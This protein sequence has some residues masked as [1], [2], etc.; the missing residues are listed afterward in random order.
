ME[1]RITEARRQNLIT[2]E[3]SKAPVRL[4]TKDQLK[5]MGINVGLSDTNSLDGSFGE[6]VS[7]GFNDDFD[8]DA[9]ESA[10]EDLKEQD[11]FKGINLN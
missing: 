11:K 8:V 9:L 2:E 10:D 4:S 3:E 1:E 5:A 6:N 7:T